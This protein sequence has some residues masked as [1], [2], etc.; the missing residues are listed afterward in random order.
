MEQERRRWG[1]WIGTVEDLDSRY[2]W[3]YE[4]RPDASWHDVPLGYKF[5]RITKIVVANQYQTALATVADER[6]PV[7][8]V[9]SGPTA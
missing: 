2:L 6:P 7:L 1:T 3:L 8:V 9:T 5:R 4:I